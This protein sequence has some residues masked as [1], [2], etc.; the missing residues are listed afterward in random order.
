MNSKTK[1][2]IGALAVAALGAVTAGLFATDEGRRTR[3]DV[4]KKARK[5]RNKTLQQ[6]GEL[7]VGARRRYETVKQAATDI[8]DEGKEK[9]SGIVGHTGDAGNAGTAGNAK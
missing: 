5:L 4:K 7:K 9:V 2:I 8:I 3:R 1:L 6:V